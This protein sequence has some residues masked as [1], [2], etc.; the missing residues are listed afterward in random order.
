MKKRAFLS[1]LLLA[2]V[3]VIGLTACQNEEEPVS[4]DTV[5]GD[6]EETN[7]MEKSSN[8]GGEFVSYQGAIYFREYGDQD[9]EST[10]QTDRYA[11][12]TKERTTKYMNAIQANG[13]IQNVFQDEGYGEI[14][15]LDHRFYLQEMPQRLY[16]VDMSGQNR[17][18]LGRGNFVA[19]QEEKH[20]LFYEN[21][22]DQN[23]L[24]LYDTSSQRITKITE[25]EVEVLAVM[26]DSLYY[27]KAAEP[28]GETDSY[29]ILERNLQTKEDLSITTLSV[30]KGYT[31]QDSLAAGQTLYLA[32]GQEKPILHGTTWYEGS[33]Y[34]VDVTTKTSRVVEEDAGNC[35]KVV[36]NHLY[37]NKCT[38]RQEYF[39]NLVEY[40]MDTQIVRIMPNSQNY[41]L[42]PNGTF[43]AVSREITL[44]DP[45]TRTEKKICTEEQREAF[46]ETYRPKEQEGT[47]VTSTKEAEV[48]MRVL[49]ATDQA[50]F[51]QLELSH[52]EG[53]GEDLIWVREA[54]EVYQYDNETGK[55]RLLYQYQAVIEE[56]SGDQGI[57]GDEKPEEP[58]KEN[59][60]YL[61]IQL[62]NKGVRNQFTVRVEEEGGTIIGKRIEYEETHTREEGKIKIKITKEMGAMVKV[63]IDNE[64][65]S[66]MLISE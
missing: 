7:K 2:I 62:S 18:E 44:W 60:M 3:V 21:A 47:P 12:Q 38:N 43:Q 64:L 24:Y 46:L 61:E 17:K 57:S 5:S 15:V 50:V 31:V 9:V 56:T 39:W 26:E 36:G 10:T 19:C 54:T 48:T 13:N 51:Y 37:Y 58:L 49:G 42:Q 6:Q 1:N 33:I 53:E 11:Y 16:S 55:S 27:A 30:T 8:Q 28:E 65:D 35:L 4:G 41:P 52:S 59:E 25:E 32:V 40:D 34:A 45:E 29:E 20:R 63:Y 14:Y 22:N 66:Q 23:A